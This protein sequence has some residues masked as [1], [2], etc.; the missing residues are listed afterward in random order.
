MSHKYLL[1]SHNS[2]SYIKP[3]KWWLRPFHFIA[4][5]QSKSIIEQ[6]FD[7]DVRVFDL[8]IRFDKEGNPVVAHGLFVFDIDYKKLCEDLDF[9]NGKKCTVRILHEVRTKRQYIEESVTRFR[10]FCSTL[11]YKYPNIT[12]YGGRNLYNWKID[13]E[14]GKEPT[15]ESF[16]SSVR[17]PYLVDDWWPWL[18]ARFNNKKV[19]KKDVNAEILAIDFVNI[20]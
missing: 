12:F 8:R 4:K 5:C 2:W 10:I 7:Y 1:Q 16:Y 18:Y 9:L 20:R 13:Y 11:E 3:K 6:Y 19:L 17:K 14:F 15:E